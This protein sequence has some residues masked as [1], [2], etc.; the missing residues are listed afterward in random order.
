MTQE[1]SKPY[2]SQIDLKCCA[3]L[4]GI[5]FSGGQENW[6]RR[7][8]AMTSALLTGELASSKNRLQKV[9]TPQ[10]CIAPAAV[11]IAPIYWRR[12]GDHFVVTFPA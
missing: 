8:P 12:H 10:A 6:C 4:E 9:R 7:K 3:V 11:V 5:S 1:S 2:D